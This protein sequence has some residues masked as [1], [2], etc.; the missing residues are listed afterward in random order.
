M[1]SI[2]DLAMQYGKK[3]LFEK[4]TVTFD[5]GKSYGLVGAN[6]SGK[7][8]L[9]RLITGEEKPYSGTIS[10]PRDL[11]VGVLQQ[12]HF[13][14]ENNRV[15]DVVLLGRPVLCE[16]LF[17]KEKLLE[18]E[19]FD[20][21]TGQRL[22]QLEEI[23]AEEEGYVAEPFA[24]EL[25]S[26]LGIGERY[27]T[28]PM[29]KLSG[30]FKLRV[31]L[32]QLLF[33]QPD[34]LLLDEPTN[35]LDIVSILWLEKY[36]CSQFA[37]TLIFISHDRNFLNAVAGYIVD[38]DYEELRLYTG[39]YEQ[40]LEAKV[41]AETQKLKEIKSYERKTAELQSFVDRFRAKATKARQAQSRVKQLDK[42]DV[43]EVKRSSRI[44]PDLSFVQSRPSGRTVLTVN[45]VS[46]KFD[47]TEVLKN[48]SFEI[49]RG[50]KVAI[51]GPNG[52]GKSTLL[53]I[54][55]DQL[56]AD[57]GTFEWGYEAHTSY[58]AQDHHEQLRGKISA[59]DWLYAT[60]PHEPIGAIRGLLGRVLFSG[61]EALKQ[62]SALSGGES[63]RLLFARIMLEKRNILILDE[64]TNHM[65]L[66]GV[67]ALGDALKAFE[68][69]VLVV[70]HYRHF[71]SKVATHILELTP[72]GV[73]DF[74][75]S[76]Q[77]YLEKFGDDY[78][79]REQP[80]STT[81]A[82]T[83]T[84]ESVPQELSYDK[85]KK[86]QREISKLKK[87]A[88]RFESLVEETELKISAIEA[89]FSIEDFFQQTS[90]DEVQKLQI[91]KSELNEQL[92]KNLRQ[93]ETS[94]QNLESLEERFGA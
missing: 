75:G 3:T 26:G 18:S 89:K 67:A 76:Y 82:Q 28:G 72:D 62:V 77:E 40:F 74:A 35:H 83:A 21:K 78:L 54:I 50:E 91:E 80:L 56:T 43:P 17:E 2:A 15:I 60:A 20:T 68:G 29:N 52:I 93:W 84:P 24:A 33:Q 85:R 58:F 10:V 70:S 14:F 71:V 8:T 11:K 81:I 39:N 44:S 30:G 86:M 16:A 53:K 51:I 61:D 34:V 41:L 42:M 92:S 63:A 87:Q 46:K 25:L 79:N 36:L 90:A 45:N 69:T 57:E 1:I 32:A 22:G 66:E 47:D 23:I 13:K 38:I 55:L 12:D 59:Y 31:L 49:Q 65:D 48:I 6:G 9:L 94:S 19:N 7:S 88:T 27:H 73:R 4:S 5:P 64:P 37:G